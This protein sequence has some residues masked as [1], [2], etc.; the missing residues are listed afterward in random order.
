M[1]SSPDGREEAEGEV[2]QFYLQISVYIEISVLTALTVKETTLT[3][4]Y[5]SNKRLRDKEWVGV[6]SQINSLV[7][8]SDIKGV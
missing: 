8:E 7:D 5:R 1:S 6:V 4:S 2:S 3:Q